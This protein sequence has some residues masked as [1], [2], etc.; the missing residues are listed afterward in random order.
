[1][2]KG[3]MEA[4]FTAFLASVANILTYAVWENNSGS[5]R[6]WESLTTC[7]HYDIIY[8]ELKTRSLKQSHSQAIQ[9]NVATKASK[10]LQKS[11]M[12]PIKWFPLT[13]QW[14]L[15]VREINLLVR[16]LIWKLNNCNKIKMIDIKSFLCSYFLLLAI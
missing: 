3:Y 15:E 13:F 1:M 10:I 7:S 6:L 16:V 8:S 2:K 5:I 4:Q 11:T 14:E 12:P 9:G